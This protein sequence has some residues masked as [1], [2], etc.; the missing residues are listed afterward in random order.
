[1]EENYFFSSNS[2]SCRDPLFIK[3][4]IL[5]FD[6]EF[7]GSRKVEVISKWFSLMLFFIMVCLWKD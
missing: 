5:V 4:R 2:C 7:L 6:L 1:L 3:P